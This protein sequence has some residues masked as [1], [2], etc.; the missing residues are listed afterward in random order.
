ML[1]QK[2]FYGCCIFIPLPNIWLKKK[3]FQFFI[4]VI[5]YQILVFNIRNL[6]G[7]FC[8]RIVLHDISLVMDHEM[9]F[10]TQGGAHEGYFKCLVMGKKI[11]IVEDKK[12]SK[13][14]SCCNC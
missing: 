11:A 9:I 14:K 5:N 2:K 7:Q 1:K 12:K 4:L 13:I 3:C 8:K 6:G 10:I